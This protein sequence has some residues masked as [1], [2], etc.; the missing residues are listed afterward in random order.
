MSQTVWRG[1]RRPKSAA[2]G[3]KRKQPRSSR[4]EA[5]FVEA[6]AL[7]RGELDLGIGAALGALLVEK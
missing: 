6:F 5:V 2:D 4:T 7:L 3:D 1:V